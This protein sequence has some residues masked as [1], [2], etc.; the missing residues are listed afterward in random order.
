[1]QERI[2]CLHDRELRGL[3]SEQCVPAGDID[4]RLWHQR[5]HLC[6][7]SRRPGMRKRL[8]PVYAGRVP[9]RMLQ[10]Q[11][12]SCRHSQQHLWHRGHSVHQ[13]PRGD[14]VQESGVRLHRGELPERLLRHRDTDL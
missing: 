4:Q 5:R 1:M 10:E 8:L 13:L 12:L 7:M 6:P 11:H 9:E 2:L 3:L 14:G